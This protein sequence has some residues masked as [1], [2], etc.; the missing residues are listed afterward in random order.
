MR[1]RQNQY[2]GTLDRPFGLWLS[3]PFRRRA[4]TTSPNSF[5]CHPS[6]ISPSSESTSRSGKEVVVLGGEAGER[7]AGAPSAVHLGADR[8][9]VHEPRLEQRPRHLL[10]RLVHPPVQ[11]DLVVER[12]EDVGDGALFGEGWEAHFLED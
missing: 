8:V 10:Q 9:E 11:L 6:G 3:E 4:S 5:T 7:L 12:S 1:A 2:S